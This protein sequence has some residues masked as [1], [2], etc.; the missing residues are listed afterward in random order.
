MSRGLR[1]ILTLTACVLIF[2]GS[3]LL[4]APGVMAGLY[5]TTVS[6]DG[7]N[8][9]RTAGAA[10]LALGVLAWLS[11][12]PDIGG[13]GG[14]GVPVLFLWFALKSY[15]AYL[16]VR[17]GVFHP[18]AGRTILFFDVA[19]AFVYGFYSVLAVRRVR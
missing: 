1:P 5:G 12:R 17:D 3:G 14:V 4:F 8:A 11:R 2:L 10:V 16:G 7:T 19:L 18:V 6:V 9:A 15:V 13:A